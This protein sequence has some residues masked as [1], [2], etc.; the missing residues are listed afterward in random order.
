MDGK[1][2]VATI[3]TRYQDIAESALRAT[4]NQYG[5]KRGCAILMEVKTGY[6]LACANLTRDTSGRLSENLWSNVACSDHSEPGSTF[7]TVA[8]TAM[9]NDKR[10]ALDTSKRVR[11]GG[12]KTYSSKSGEIT[13]HGDAHDT[14]N[15][16]GVLAQSSNIG[17][18]ELAW[19]YYRDRRGDF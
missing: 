7:K 5:G 11:V 18:C 10:I 2:I 16:A 9:L 8:M 6:V 12:K 4:M 3:D 1:S 13:H 17:M 14:S 15:L 19:E